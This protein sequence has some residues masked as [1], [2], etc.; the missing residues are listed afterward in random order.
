MLQVEIKNIDELYRKIWELTL[1]GALRK[2]MSK[3]MFLTER[4][5]KLNTPVDT[6]LLRNSYET[7]I[8]DFESTIRNFREYAPY[9]EARRWF[10]SQTVEETEGKVQDIF[11]TEINDLLRNI[12]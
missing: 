8:W 1:R 2:A 3:S 12:T 7:S 5:A 11:V 4:N 6:G 10:M 9:V